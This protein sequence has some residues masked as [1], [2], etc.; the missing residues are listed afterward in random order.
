MSCRITLNGVF[1]ENGE[2]SILYKD[3]E[4]V[5]TSKKDAEN[6]Y[7]LSETNSFKNNVYRPLQQTNPKEFDSNGEI[8]Y[9]YVISYAK[10]LNTTSEKLSTQEK[11]D[12]QEL[13]LQNSN[14]KDS[15]DLLRE[16]ERAFY[17]EDG[18]FNPTIKS[19]TQNGLYSSYEAQNIINDIDLQEKIKTSIER[20]GNSEVIEVELDNVKMQYADKQ[21]SLNSFGKLK[22]KNPYI[23]EQRVIQ[24]YGGKE[25][26]DLD[27]VENVKLQKH[28]QNKENR[29]ELEEE[30]SEYKRLP[31]LKQE[32][33]DLV[34]ATTKTIYPNAIKLT[35]D[36]QLISDLQVL[37]ETPT[38]LLQTEEALNYVKKLERDLAKV[39]IDVVGLSENSNYIEVTE[40]L[41]E[42]LLNPNQEN[43]NSLE[44]ALTE[45]MGVQKTPQEQVLRLDSEQSL[46]YIETTLSEEEMFDK[47]YLKTGR[48]N[49]YQKIEKIPFVELQSI[50]MEDMSQKE[51]LDLLETESRKLKTVNDNQKAQEI[52]AYKTVFNQPL[53]EPQEK[54]NSREI[55]ERQ[56]M[57]DGNEQYLKEDFVA[58]FNATIIEEKRKQSDDYVNF[59]SKFKI[60]EKGIEFVSKDPLTISNLK[61][62]LESGAMKNTKDIINYSLL[63]KNIPSL[64]SEEVPTT[65][66]NK[67]T[68]RVIY[69]NNPQ[70]LKITDKG[71][72]TINED[73]ITME[74]ATEPFIRTPEGIFEL[75]RTKGSTNLYTRLPLNED[76]NYY[77]LSEIDLLNND[78][79][80]EVNSFVTEKMKE[81]GFVKQ[82]NIL[83]KE[84]NQKITEGNFDCL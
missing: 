18:L 65:F 81:G 49:I 30:F 35:E 10:D 6:L 59:Y 74:N 60:T 20:L 16:L 63:S 29:N 25:N 72:S 34:Q 31:Y 22:V 17:S 41:Q 79:I 58:D 11:I 26:I 7:A 62:W 13:L 80:D 21:N 14:L 2:L 27:E 47:G 42:F 69:S 73:F 54:F 77:N 52:V 50:L 32:G 28:I 71:Y 15:S 68:L 82:R 36:T 75:T 5:T 48:K 44:Q 1:A 51:M 55:Q 76:S 39:G 4:T 38:E 83:T 37:K 9:K 12:T 78:I 56:Q 45:V 8:K 43:T 19:L 66:T 61:T 67:E 3:L 53:V 40:P 24:E 57:F 70:S 23:E 64:S 46:H 33:E 84:E